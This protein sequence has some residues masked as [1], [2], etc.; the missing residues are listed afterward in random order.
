MAL[1]RKWEKF[2]K[3]MADDHAIDL[4][5]LVNELL[6]WAFSEPEGKEQFKTWLD[7]SYPPKG[8]AEEESH[9]HRP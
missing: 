3:R 1:P 9:E 8:E 4:N 5:T 2:L 7:E 6:E